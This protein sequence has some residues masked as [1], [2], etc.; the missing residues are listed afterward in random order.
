MNDEEAHRHVKQAEAFITLKRFNDAL[1]EALHATD[2][3]P[4]RYEAQAEMGR[5]MQSVG[6]CL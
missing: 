1:D 5:C 4:S 6:C 3:E 2:K